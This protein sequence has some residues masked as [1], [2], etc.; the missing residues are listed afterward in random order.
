MTVLDGI[1]RKW[2]EY[3]GKETYEVFD[4][5]N[6]GEGEIE[7][8]EKMLKG[9]QAAVLEMENDLKEYNDDYIY[10]MFE[11][12]F[13]DFIVSEDI[14]EYEQEF[15]EMNPDI[16]DELRFEFEEHLDFNFETFYDYDILIF[17]KMYPV[18]YDGMQ[19]KIDWKDSQS[20]AFRRRALK[21]I[22]KEEF[23]SILLNAYGGEGYIAAIVNGTELLTAIKDDKKTVGGNVVVGVHDWMNG[24]GMYEESDKYIDLKLENASIDTGD[25]GVGGVFGTV[26]W[27]Y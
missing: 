23:N 13:E 16:K 4:Y 12:A 1:M 14:S 25:Y 18:D 24:A 20:V 10:S 6:R 9:G 11:S 17:E 19:T 3:L 7:S 2:K 8:L 5:S 27:K 15:L 21:Y 22:T 26:N